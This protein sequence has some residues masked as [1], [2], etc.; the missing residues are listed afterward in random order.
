M[1]NETKTSVYIFLKDVRLKNQK[2]LKCFLRA[3]KCFL[4]KKLDFILNEILL[5]INDTIFLET[6][7]H[8]I[9]Q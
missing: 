2:Q 5:S 4:T 3:V 6:R 7:L 1:K 8:L 9:P